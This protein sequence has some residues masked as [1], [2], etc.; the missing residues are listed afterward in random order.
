M[1]FNTIKFDITEVNDLLEK[2]KNAPTE[3]KNRAGTIC[4]T[5]ASKTKRDYRSSINYGDG[6]RRA[7]AS[8]NGKAY[9]KVT[10]KDNSLRVEVGHESFIAKFVEVGTRPHRIQTNRATI[11]HPGISGTHAL[12]IAWNKNFASLT[13]QLQNIL[14]TTL[15]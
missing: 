9:S 5:W 11:Q 7:P 6:L 4:R 15:E 2:W 8:A 1:E 14:N 3:I 10:I 12:Q 13:S